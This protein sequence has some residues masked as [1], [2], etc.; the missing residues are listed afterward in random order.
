MH[1]RAGVRSWRAVAPE[2]LPEVSSVVHDA[3]F[4]ADSV[5]YDRGRRV[6][7][8]PFAQEWWEPAE[9]DPRPEL[10][11]KT[12]RYREERVPFVHGV[13]H[14]RHVTSFTAEPDAGDAGMLLGVRYDANER[15]VTID[16]VSGD[17][18]ALVDEL[19]VAAELHPG[20]VARYVLRRYG[21]LGSSEAAG[22]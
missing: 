17:L 13:L 5:E 9:D 3:Y 15:R 2:G 11:R 16:G 14:V 12:W 4:D 8:V 18:T 6:L 1:D 7:S 22:G 19:D 21:R 10:V 20:E